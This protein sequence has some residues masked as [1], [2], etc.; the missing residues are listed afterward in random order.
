VR[1][2]RRFSIKGRLYLTVSAAGGALPSGGKL[3]SSLLRQSG[4]VVWRIIENITES[5]KASW[6]AAC[7]GEAGAT[8]KCRAMFR[9]IYRGATAV[10]RVRTAA[11]EELLSDAFAV[12]RGVVQGDIFSPLGFILAL[13]CIML[14]HDSQSEGI[15]VGKTWISALAYAD[16]AALLGPGG[17]E[18]VERGTKR[19]TSLAAGANWEADC[20]ISVKKTEAMHARKRLDVGA[21]KREDYEEMKERGV[22][23]FVCEHCSD[24]SYNKLGLDKHLLTC[25]EAQREEF[26]EPSEVEEIL[27]VR[28]PPHRRFY[29]VHWNPGQWPWNP[30]GPKGVRNPSWE[31]SRFLDGCQG[32]LADFWE[33]QPPGVGSDWDFANPPGE[34]RCKWCSRQYF[35]AYAGRSLK[36]HYT[37]KPKDG[38]CDCVPKNKVGTKTEEAVLRQKQVDLQVEAGTVYIGEDPLYNCFDFRYLGAAFQADGCKR[39]APMQRM[40]KARAVMGRL[41]DIWKSDKVELE[42]KLLL[43]KS[44]VL[45]VLLYGMEGWYLTPKVLSSLKGFNARN[46]AI[47]T[48]KE[49]K[50]ES[51]IHP[52]VDVIGMVRARRLRWVGH[53]LRAHDDYLPRQVVLGMEKPYPAGSILMDA[54][55][56]D[57]MEELVV[58]AGDRDE[59]RDLVCGLDG[60]CDS[61]VYS[62]GVLNTVRRSERIA[63]QEVEQREVRERPDSK[64]GLMEIPE[65]L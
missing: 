52:T 36:T 18:G 11:G 55:K 5:Y 21:M 49:I 26:A 23:K 64:W 4:R 9:A 7:L 42:T 48:G 38:G 32:L 29:K 3:R 44:S 16:D 35:G 2:H 31:P 41:F 63:Q 53:V 19:V 40:L 45:S 54:P 13:Q 56:H 62:R 33:A 24:V 17:K 12:Q 27:D 14:H 28:G 30:E 65:S 22:L 50:E 6:Q 47:I 39:F 25:G 15:L 57:S 61:S 10:V 1:G 58:L 60:D 51:G 37:K 59:W 34:F 20:N 46:L 43:Y 8:T